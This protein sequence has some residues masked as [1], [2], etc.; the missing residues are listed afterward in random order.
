MMLSQMF[1]SS[2]DHDDLLFILYRCMSSDI[3]RNTGV[4]LICICM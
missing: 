3:Q 1:G 2:L 4:I